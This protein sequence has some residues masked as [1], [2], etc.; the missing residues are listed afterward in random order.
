MAEETS[1]IVNLLE[2]VN[3][4]QDWKDI[5]KA[6]PFHI[7]IREDGEYV[8]LKYSQY[9]TDMSYLIAQQCRGCILRQNESGQYIYVCRPFDKFLTMVKNMQLRSIGKQHV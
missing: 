9:D 6:A 5:L 7:S 4:H 3:E 2:F 1:K 8:L